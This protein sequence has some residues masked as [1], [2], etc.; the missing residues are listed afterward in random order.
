MFHFAG[1][2]QRE[3]GI[4]V[5]WQDLNLLYLWWKPLKLF[6]KAFVNLFGIKLWSHCEN[7]PALLLSQRIWKPPFKFFFCGQKMHFLKDSIT[8]FCIPILFFPKHSCLLPMTMKNKLK[9]FTNF[10]FLEDIWLQ[11]FPL[12]SLILWIHSFVK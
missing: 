2:V 5:H 6:K 9:Q 11:R 7:Q 4:G 12:N 1:H 10:C 8:R 3:P